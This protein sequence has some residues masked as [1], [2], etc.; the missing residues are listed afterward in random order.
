MAAARALL[1]ESDSSKV[2]C[3]LGNR[4]LHI[5]LRHQNMV[6]GWVGLYVILQTGDGED[7]GTADKYHVRFFAVQAGQLQHIAAGKVGS[8]NCRFTCKPRWSRVWCYQ[9]ALGMLSVLSL[10]SSSVP[11]RRT[12]TYASRYGLW[13]QTAEP[14]AVCDQ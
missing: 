11:I 8:S 5:Q 9:V 3:S 13:T 4:R 1:G 7:F 12:C 14:G 10:S 2:V 6:E